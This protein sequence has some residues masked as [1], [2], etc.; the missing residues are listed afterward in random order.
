MSPISL[1]V[2]GTLISEDVLQM[3][4]CPQ[5]WTSPERRA[6]LSTLQCSPAILQ[7][8]KRVR[9]KQADYPAIIEGEASEAVEGVIIEGLTDMDIER[10]DRYEG[11]EYARVQVSV[12][13]STG[14]FPAY[15][16]VWAADR[17]FL[18]EH[19]WDFQEFA[20]EK[21]TAWLKN[22]RGEFVDV[23]ALDDK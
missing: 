23:F 1:F 18:E 21:L 7:G 6:K 11:D 4:L 19:T 10:L 3:V 17:S 9:V 8:Y 14:S 2:Y 13:T 20:R 5:H 15:T 12:S 22:G 16:Y